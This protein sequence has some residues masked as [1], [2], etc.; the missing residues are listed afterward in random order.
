MLEK[1]ETKSDI[2]FIEKNSDI[3]IKNILVFLKKILKI[4]NL[5]NYI[6]LIF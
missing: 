3:L 5:I 6:I 2:S 1:S 4:T